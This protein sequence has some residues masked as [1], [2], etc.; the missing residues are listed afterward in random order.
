MCDA[1]EAL[2]YSGRQLDVGIDH[3]DDGLAGKAKDLI[4]RSWEA[5]VHPRDLQGELEPKPSAFGQDAWTVSSVDALSRILTR[6]AIPASATDLSSRPMVARELN[7]TMHVEH[8]VRGWEA[9]AS[10]EESRP[11]GLAGGASP[12][13]TP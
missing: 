3:R 7:V 11:D 9:T 4:A 5:H 13:Y 8:T 10:T 12:L 2:Q 6:V 1:G